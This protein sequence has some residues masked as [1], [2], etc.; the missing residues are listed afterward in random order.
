VNA[1]T[2]NEAGAL[3][4]FDRIAN[5]PTPYTDK[6]IALAQQLKDEADQPD[7]QDGYEIDAAG[8]FEG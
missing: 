1:L 5:P 4:L 8:T 7:N 2:K 6:L 3:A